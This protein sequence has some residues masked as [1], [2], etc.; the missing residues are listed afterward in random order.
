MASPAQRSLAAAVGSLTRWSR[1]HGAD[2]RRQATQAMR[3]GR[4]RKLEQQ[5]IEEAGRQLAP[6]ELDEAVERLKKAHYR[7]MALASAKARAAT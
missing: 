5:A 2:G 4:R 6:D 1:V 7:R 3:D